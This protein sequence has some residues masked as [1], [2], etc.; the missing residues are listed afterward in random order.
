[1]E[2]Q[3]SID[4]ARVLA[5]HPLEQ[6]AVLASFGG[7]A[8]EQPVR[9][10]GR[11]AQREWA[12]REWAQCGLGRRSVWALEFS[13]SEKACFLQPENSRAG[14]AMLSADEG[15]QRKLT[16]GFSVSGGRG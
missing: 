11:L 4:A 15:G 16:R 8:A 7:G 6:R 9:A 12:Q 3:L 1:M 10:G 5:L 2:A 14:S 13:S